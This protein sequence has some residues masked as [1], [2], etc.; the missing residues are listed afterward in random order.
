MRWGGVDWIGLAQD[1]DKCRGLVNAVM[2]LRVPSNAG[3]LSSG[4]QPIEIVSLPCSCC[5]VSMAVTARCKAH[6]IFCQLGSWVRFPSG[7]GCIPTFFT[8]SCCRVQVKA[9]V[10]NCESQFC[11]ERSQAA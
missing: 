3:K 11:I 5:Y 7:R 10:H 8:C 2:S 4:A 9:P 1:R 6:P